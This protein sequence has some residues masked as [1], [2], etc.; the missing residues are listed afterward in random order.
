LRAKLGHTL[1]AV[2][3]VLCGCSGGGGSIGGRAGAL[4]CSVEAQKQSV[5]SL[6]QAWY[7]Y[8]DEPEQQQKYAALDVGQYA[9]PDALLT[10]LLYRPERFDRNF[11]FLTTTAADQQFFGEGQFVGFGFGSKFADSPLDADLRLTQV[12]AASPAA[13][14]GLARGQ[15]ILAIDGRTI[16]AIG[17]AEGLT[18][19]LGPN[20]V[21]VART[22]S[23]RRLDGTEFDAAIAKALVTIDPVPFRTTFSVGATTVGYLDFRTFVSTAD[24]E[25]EDAFEAFE[26]ADVSRLIVD[27]RYNG[28]G[29]VVT[30]QRLANL[31]GGFI[32][33]GQVQSRT[34]FNSARSALDSVTSYEQRANSLTLL[35]QVVFITTASSASASEIVINALEPH[36][37]VRLV[38]A[39]TFGK[40]VGQSA[41]DFCGGSRLLRAV[42]FETVNS[43][44]AGDYYD[45]L[46]VDCPAE[47]ELGRAVGDPLEASLATAL[48]VV[49]T[50]SC[51]APAVTPKVAAAPTS[52]VDPPIAPDAPPAQ[53]YA[54]AL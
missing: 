19:A 2:C 18:A 51:P 16:A 52:L 26:A 40:P 50:D 5:A 22:F 13:A 33:A 31:I 48:T 47:D 6:M 14:A 35:H 49:E 4:A 1:A 39:T 45:G 34:H 43:L 8:N 9:T 41:L 20:D 54:G 44:G 32:A 42:T 11:S 7:L 21:G 30:A 38:G 10:A 25:L 29:L 3:V 46:S 17:Q 15:R 36:T 12:F 37:D 27:L 24:A 28:G 23:V 53:R